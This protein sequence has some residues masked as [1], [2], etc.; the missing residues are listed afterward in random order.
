MVGD[1]SGTRNPSFKFSKCHGEMGLKHVKER[2]Y[3]RFRTA[4]L[5]C[6]TAVRK[7]KILAKNEENQPCSTC[8][9]SIFRL[10]LSNRKSDFGYYL[11]P[12]PLFRNKRFA[13]NEMFQRKASKASKFAIF[14]I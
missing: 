6:S 12:I 11:N 3:I 1:G 8:L 4:I 9:E 13:L 2:P 14:Y 5:Y 7:L 10:I